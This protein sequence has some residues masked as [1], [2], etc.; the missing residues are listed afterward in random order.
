MSVA[1]QRGLPRW[2][3]DAYEAMPPDAGAAAFVAAVRDHSGDGDASRMGDGGGG[4]GRARAADKNGREHRVLVA[5]DALHA[6][7]VTVCACLRAC[8]SVAASVKQACG[9]LYQGAWCWR[10]GG[11]VASHGLCVKQQPCL[12]W[13][14]RPVSHRHRINRLD[15]PPR[16]P[17]V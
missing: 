1:S 11:A 15:L 8:V 6:V 4:D 2:V 16:I 3:L 14:R 10:G 5:C 9:T 12:S 7:V 17:T 13:A